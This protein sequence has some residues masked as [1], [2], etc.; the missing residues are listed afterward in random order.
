MKDDRRMEPRPRVRPSTKPGTPKPRPVRQDGA[1]APQRARPARPAQGQ[2]QG[3]R[4]SPAR[5]APERYNGGYAPGY[6]DEQRRRRKRP[7]RKSHKRL[8]PNWGRALGYSAI[9]VIAALVIGFLVQMFLFQIIVVSGD[10]MHKMLV[11]G[12]WVFLTKYDY[13]S[14][15]PQRGDVVAVRTNEG[16]VIRRVVGMPGEALAIDQHGDTLING[17]PLG[18][19]YVGLISYDEYPA[20]ELPLGWYFVMCDNRTVKFDSRDEK[21]GPVSRQRIVGKVKTILFPFDKS[22][23]IQ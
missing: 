14:E 20:T 15:A 9:S 8:K 10:A 3:Q 16:L 1:A 18:E 21:M 4:Q 6:A 11:G 22:G 17:D 7:I 19:P 2:G 23:S 12:E 13:W 5:R